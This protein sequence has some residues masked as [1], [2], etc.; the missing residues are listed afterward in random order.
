MQARQ[1]PL[2]PE[3]CQRPYFFFGLADDFLLRARL[4][5]PLLDN[6]A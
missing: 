6:W 3:L 5:R 1:S 2:D 4:A